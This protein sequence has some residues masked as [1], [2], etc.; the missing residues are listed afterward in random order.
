MEA[1]ELQMRAMAL[2]IAARVYDKEGPI[3]FENL[4]E[5]IYGFLKNGA[6]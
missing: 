1:T 2:D 5:A 3:P 6:F 4:A